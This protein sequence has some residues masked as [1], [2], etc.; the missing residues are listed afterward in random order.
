MDI[1]VQIR[2]AKPPATAARTMFDPSK[3][4]SWISGVLKSE[5]LRGLHPT[6]VGTRVRRRGM[7]LG[8]T[9]SCVT[10]VTAS[11][12]N[13]K[14]VMRFVEGPL[15]GEVSYDI[16]PTKRGCA[17]RV[18]SN[19]SAHFRIPGMSWLLRRSIGADLRRLKSIVEG[20]DCLNRP[21]KSRAKCRSKRPFPARLRQQLLE[22]QHDGLGLSHMYDA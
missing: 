7:I 11:E 13:R 5:F 12:T 17:V 9:I 16:V 14:L 10:E 3:D 15:K 20:D 4:S 2:I 6:I 22:D 19:T 8:Q 1:T 18:R 21:D